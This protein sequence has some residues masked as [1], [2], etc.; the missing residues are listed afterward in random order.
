[1]KISFDSAKNEINIQTRQL[2]FTLVTELDW[3]NALMVEDDRKDYGERRFRV[4]GMI[5][6]RLHALVFTPRLDKVHVISLRKANLREEKQY[7]KTIKT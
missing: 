6:T 7:E 2:P 4:L 1:M 5:G 3:S